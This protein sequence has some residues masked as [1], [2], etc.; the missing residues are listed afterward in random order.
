M[1]Y[2]YWK[3]KWEKYLLNFLLILSVINYI[4]KK[5]KKIMSILIIIFKIK[6]Y[7]SGTVNSKSFVSKV[8]LR[9]KWKFKLINAL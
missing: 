4:W 6:K 8:L 2:N 7:R 3:L 5:K 9:I 1:L